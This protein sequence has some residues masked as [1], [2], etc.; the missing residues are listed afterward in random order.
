MG[1][2]WMK[3]SDDISTVEPTVDLFVVMQGAA[4]GAMVS[5]YPKYVI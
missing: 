1:D 3:L 5:C 4:S 2:K